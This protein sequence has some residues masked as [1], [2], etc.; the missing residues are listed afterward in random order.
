MKTITKAQRHAC[1]KLYLRTVRVIPP[2]SY[3]KFRR[4]A[5]N[6]GDCLMVPFYGMVCG[7]ETDGYCHS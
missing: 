4:Q 5:H 7:I 1:F 3:L 2:P 6:M